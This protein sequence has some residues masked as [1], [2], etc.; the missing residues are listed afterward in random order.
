M[1]YYPDEPGVFQVWDTEAESESSEAQYE[2]CMKFHAGG[3]ASE[4]P[5]FRVLALI[6]RPSVR[7]EIRS[8]PDTGML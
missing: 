3:E 6:P 5:V 8:A 7:R 1:G 2:V 4:V